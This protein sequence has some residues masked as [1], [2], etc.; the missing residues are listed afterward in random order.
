MSD[1]TPE[2]VVGLGLGLE[3]SQEED[4]NFTPKAK[5]EEYQ[6]LDSKWH[7]REVAVE[8]D[9][10]ASKQGPPKRQRLPTAPLTPGEFNGGK[11]E[12]L[13]DITV[14]PS[15][16]TKAL[17]NVSLIDESFPEP[18][19]KLVKN[20]TEDE[21]FWTLPAASQPS[22]S[23]D[24]DSKRVSAL[25]TRSTVS[26]I[27]EAILVDGPPQRTKTLRHMKKNKTLRD[28]SSAVAASSVRSSAQAQRPEGQ[29]IPRR[30]SR[31][32]RDRLHDSI[33][34]NKTR[35]S[36]SSNRA[37]REVW[38]SGRVPVAIIPERRSSVKSNRPPS[39]RSTGSRRSKRSYSVGPVPLSS[40]SASKD[41]TPFFERPSRRRQ[42]EVSESDNSDGQHTIDYPPV[43][44][45][46]TSSLSVAT[47]RNASRSTSRGGSRVDSLNEPEFLENSPDK[48]HDG[49]EECKQGVPEVKLQRAATLETLQQPGEESHR[50]A[51]S[52]HLNVN[53]NGDPLFGSRHSIHK[54]PFSQ[55][56][57][58]TNGTSAAEVSE[59][60]A[61]NIYAHQ[62][63][64]VLMVDH[65]TKPSESSDQSANTGNH[66]ASRYAMK[67]IETDDAMTRPQLVLPPMD[68]E[69]TD[70]PL[71]NPRAPPEPPVLHDPPALA[72]I[73]ATPSGMTPTAEKQKMLGNFYDELEEKPTKPLLAS[74]MR[75]RRHSDSDGG[76]FLQGRRLLIDGYGGGRLLSRTFSL[77]R[78]SRRPMSEE[79]NI[80]RGKA[81][82]LSARAD[83]Y[84]NSE[85]LPSDETKLHPF[86]KPQSSDSDEEGGWDSE[87]FHGEDDVHYRY[88]IINNRPSPKRRS[89]SSRI[90]RTFAILPI[91]PERGNSVS[92]YGGNSR[93][94]RTI[95]R[96]A[97]GNLR[98]MKKHRTFDNIRQEL[99]YEKSAQSRPYA[100]STRTSNSPVREHSLRHKGRL[101]VVSQD[102]GNGEMKPRSPSPY[103]HG[104]P[105]RYSSKLRE[106]LNDYGL[107]IL[108]Q[109]LSDKRR[110]K[111]SRE[112]R[113]KI[114]AP[115]EVRDGVGDII[116]RRDLRAGFPGPLPHV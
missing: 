103:Y 5:A 4:I 81:E 35:S 74:R 72:F 99:S 27:V 114:S 30:S 83:D 33:T 71:R 42:A 46:R 55:T 61:V 66:L 49:A 53:N 64:S 21:G 10:N 78:K 90:K 50:D 111:R 6:V 80:V 87:V 95:Q 94:R 31:S 41:L 69:D 39:L 52:H 86:W 7:H 68:I 107:Q 12:V 16:A 47:S 58:E 19:P 92:S 100:T 77:S 9:G 93:D 96:T 98:V 25:S 75:S 91:A 44:P 13:E 97:S 54:T 11:T 101:F 85:N 56:S 8:W 36:I 38:K 105:K 89:L 14:S 110:E 62:N 106:I 20:N 104:Q 23:N 60:M 29:G 73:P 3:L 82:E 48:K 76:G 88:P 113:G 51:D 57:G 116:R 28:S 32:P 112:L 70:S 65:S 79:I 102:R 59:A 26:T 45:A 1:R 108:P 24:T 43:V 67:K 109:R 34:S 22:I 115:R 2:A 17:R 84:L 15:N 18:S 63:S 40:L 37:T